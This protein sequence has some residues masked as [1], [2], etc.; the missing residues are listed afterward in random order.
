[1]HTT[2]AVPAVRDTGAGAR[3]WSGWV[4]I[5]LLVIQLF[6]ALTAFAGGAALIAG[7]LDPRLGSVLVPPA[8][9]LAG[10]P[11]TWY[12][13]PGVILA[14]VLGGVHLVAFVMVL[15]HHRRAGL[16]SAA[17]GFAALIWS[18]VQM[19]FIPFSVLQ[20]VYFVAGMVEIGLVLLGLGVV[21][22]LDGPVRHAR[23][24]GRPPE[25]GT[26][27]DGAAPRRR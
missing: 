6:V 10:S 16:G 19:V 1:M 24:G 8:D 25:G 4:R 2:S 18:F 22:P 21:R 14:M 11:F 26:L 17:A 3:M 13:V 23:A 12:T 20:A 27:D 9:Y 5:P 7:S 15:R